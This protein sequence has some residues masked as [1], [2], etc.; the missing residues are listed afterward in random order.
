MSRFLAVFFLTMSAGAIAQQAQYKITLK[1]Y[2]GYEVNPLKAPGS[3]QD[4]LGANANRSELWNNLPFVGLGA[5]WQSQSKTKRHILD[6]SSSYRS[7][8]NVSDAP[9]KSAIADFGI[10]YTAKGKKR[11]SNT[12]KVRYRD[13]VKT[14]EDQDNLLG[15]PLSYKRFIISN[16]LTIK[17]K[18]HWRL[19]FIP[20]SI[21][22]IYNRDGYDQFTYMNNGLNTQLGYRYHLKNRTGYYLNMVVAQRN[23]FIK[24]GNDTLFLEDD[25]EEIDFEEE[26]VESLNRLWRYYSIT[27]GS[28]IPMNKRLKLLFGFGY[29]LRQDVWDENFGF[30]QT[31]AELG[32]QMKHKDWK[33]GFNASH[34]GRSY[35]SL[36]ATG[37]ENLLRYNYLKFRTNLQYDFRPGAS[38][39]VSANSTTR[40]SSSDSQTSRSLRSYFIGEFSVGLR[41]VIKGKYSVNK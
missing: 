38:V 26:E 1:P 32:I 30:G 24:K 36:M 37:G 40:L 13:F 39:F 34:L 27:A 18:N 3:F 20:K 31:F 29:T 5:S 19:Q 23:H 8:I 41:I 12:L 11:L 9:V 21:L 17:M 22:K 2:V 6:F 16:D 25:F 7:S 15:A 10:D 28:K 4:S 14:G 33:F 35:S